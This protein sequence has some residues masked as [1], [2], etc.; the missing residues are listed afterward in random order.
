[1]GQLENNM[2]LLLG[3]LMICLIACVLL[4]HPGNIGGQFG[5]K[6]NEYGGC[7]KVNE[8]PNK[9]TG[10][11]SNIEACRANCSFPNPPIPPRMRPTSYM[12]NTSNGEC[13]PMYRQLPDG[14]KYFATMEECRYKCGQNLNSSRANYCN[15][16]ACTGN[17]DPN[18]VKDCCVDMCLGNPDPNCV[19]NCM[20]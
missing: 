11:Y 3:F 12:C 4:F 9:D 1:M 16:I 15:T 5:F 2:L 14:K 10:V 8:A 19:K 17:P 20:N 7:D 13:T 18:C 6:C